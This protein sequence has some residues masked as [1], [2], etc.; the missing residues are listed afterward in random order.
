[1]KFARFPLDFHD[2]PAPLV[3]NRAVAAVALGNRLM[4]RHEK[5]TVSGTPFASFLGLGLPRCTSVARKRF[6]TFYKKLIFF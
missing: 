6:A 2:F 4:D 3:G 5:S 1:M